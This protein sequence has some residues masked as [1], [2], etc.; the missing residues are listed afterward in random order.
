MIINLTENTDYVHLGGH[1]SRSKY[2]V[3]KL[4]N[5]GYE[6]FKNNFVPDYTSHGQK[7]SFAYGPYKTKSKAKQ[8]MDYFSM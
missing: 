4:I 3:G 6:I 5:G 1:W 7:Y 8:T 2:F